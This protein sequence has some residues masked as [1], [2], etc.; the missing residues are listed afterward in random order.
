MPDS[1]VAD[2]G[3][4]APERA[5]PPVIGH[6]GAAG[7]APENTLAGLREAKSLGC[8]WVEFDV[9]LTADG[10]PV[11]LHDNRL[12]RT[13]NGRGRVSVLPLAE[14]RLHDAGEWFGPSFAG[15]RVPTLEEAVALLAELGLG[16]N[17]ELKATRGREAETGIV[18]AD[19]LG[20]IW[21]GE[22]PAP[23][24]SSF[25][26]KAL[27]AAQLRAPGIARGILFGIIPRNWRAIAKRCG[28]ATV[29]ADHQ[30]LSPAKIS[31]IRRSGYPVLAY[32]VNDRRRAKTLFDWGVT[33]VFSDAP[34]RIDSAAPRGG[35]RQSIAAD[36]NTA[37]TPRRGSVW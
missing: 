23:L 2:P 21:P 31:E 14:V 22:L 20:R 18:V 3:G 34:Q 37:G 12:K 16:A 7:S 5:I 35:S 4:G 27:A 24:I 26:P 1:L 13:T 29:H 15:E 8:R 9:R 30:R 11:L 19:L 32:T 33:S 10:H 17:I 6:R 25:L 28:C 36:P